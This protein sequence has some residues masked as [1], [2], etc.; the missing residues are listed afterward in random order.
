M[1]VVHPERLI[2]GATLEPG[3]VILGLPSS[4]LH[5]NGLTLA[6][7]ILLGEAPYR[8]DTVLPELGRTVGDALLEATRIYVREFLALIEGG[9][10]V[11]A[12][13]HIS[14]DGWLNL[15][16]YQRQDVGMRVD[17]VPDP[18]PLFVLIQELGTVSIDEMY[19]TFNMGL[20]F[21]VVVG[22]GHVDQATRILKDQGSEAW[23]LGEVVVGERRLVIE[24]LGLVSHGGSLVP[25]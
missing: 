13:F 18:P 3:D 22:E 5:C 23:R 2:T 14:G 21:A 24:P 25:R 16:R 10:A 17:F 20:G 1:G 9:V 11:K 6:R 8:V 19:R 15:L 4:G 12:L 7:R